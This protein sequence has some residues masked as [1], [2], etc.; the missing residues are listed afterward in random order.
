M[1]VRKLFWEDPYLTKARAV[2]TAVDGP[3]I[4]LDRTVAFAFSGGQASD[5]GWIGSY[6]ILG[7]E[8]RG[9]EILYSIP[10]GHS[11]SVGDRVVVRIDW[12]QRYRIMR[13][14]FA[15][16]LVLELV[17]QLLG[18][19]QKIGANITADK[20]R[21]DFKWQGNI[22]E[23]FPRLTEALETLVAADLPIT[24]A[25]SDELLQRRHWEIDGFARVACGG[26]HLR[27][28]GEVGAVTLRRDNIGAGKERIE[29]RLKDC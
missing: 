23:T 4:T 19:P 28:T 14:H 2:V 25:F 3:V 24:S 22:A 26:T 8:K 13:L 7:A 9:A 17:N 10:E 27:R 5:T 29:I 12:E 15:A 18:R 11:L 21:L 16:E 6:E 1:A 20:A